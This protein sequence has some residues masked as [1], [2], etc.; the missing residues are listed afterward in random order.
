MSY[1]AYWLTCLQ[2]A[3]AEGA[4]AARDFSASGQQDSVLFHAGG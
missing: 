4:K 2:N 1:L 3:D